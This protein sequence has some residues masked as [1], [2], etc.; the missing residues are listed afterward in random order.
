MT[1][2]P[3]SKGLSGATFAEL[4]LAPPKDPAAP[5][6]ELGQAEFFDLMVAQLKFQD[7]IK[8]VANTEFVAQLA[9]FSN[10]RALGDIQESMAELVGAFQ[11]SQ[12]LQA[13]TLVGRG[14]L[15]PGNAA[16]L[17][18]GEEVSGVLE[19]AERAADVQ[20]SVFHPSGELVRRIELG[21]G[22]AGR[23][24]FAWDGLDAQGAPAPPGLYTLS[25]DGVVGGERAALPML[26][27]AH[28]DSVT[29]RQHPPGA[30]LNLSGLGPVDMSAVR[31]LL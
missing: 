12:A 14:V 21:D 20:V 6:K 17:N 15:V 9:Q 22:E 2:P 8:P 30:T 18:P 19:L 10:V 13:S 28:V 31:E 3:D 5:K 4:G 25:A 26:V 7:P 11:S 29:L 27:A 16:E 23:L 1:T 24:P